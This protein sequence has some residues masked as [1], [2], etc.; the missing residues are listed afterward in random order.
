MVIITKDKL[1]SSN[2]TALTFFFINSDKLSKICSLYEGGKSA[3]YLKSKCLVFQFDIF[4]VDE[5]RLQSNI[6]LGN[7]NGSFAVIKITA[8]H[9]KIL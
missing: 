3:F 6:C 8:L 1:S 5:F 2:G 7:A 9:Y 4:A